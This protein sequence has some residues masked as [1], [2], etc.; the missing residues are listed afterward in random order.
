M[1]QDWEQGMEKSFL[2]DFCTYC[3]ITDTP[4]I[5]HIGIW[6]I[7]GGT[8]VERGGSRNLVFRTNPV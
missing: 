1:T 8:K 7:L 6:S 4:Q 5:K 2:Q 3:L